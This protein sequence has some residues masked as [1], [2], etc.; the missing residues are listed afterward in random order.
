MVIEAVSRTP[1]AEMTYFLHIMPTRRKTPV[2]PNRKVVALAY[3]GLATFEFAI[4]VEVFG[5]H[6]PEVGP[7]W[8]EFAVA[9]VD[10][11]PLR[12]TGGI[13]VLVDGGLE[14]LADAGTIVLPG[15]R[16]VDSPIGARLKGALLS[17]HARGARIVSVCS[18]A[19]ALAQTGLLD[20]CHATT[21]WRYMERFRAQFPRVHLDTDVLY[22][23]AGRLFTSAGSAAG[24]DL[25][26]HLVRRDFGS[27]VTNVVAR[28]M[29][30]P[31]HRDG[32]QQ[33]YVEQP[34]PA[35]REGAVLS[36][37]LDSLRVRLNRS[38]SVQRL[39]REARMSERTFVRRFAAATGMPPGKWL[40][41]ERVRRAKHL[42]ETRALSIDATAAECGFADASSLW[43]HFKA[44]VGISP[45]AYRSRFAR[46]DTRAS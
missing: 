1:L 15:W 45:A 38:M 13:R 20:G 44:Q 25:C 8:Y 16:G 10:P 12:A 29:V 17:A 22:V 28:R 31:P 35:A 32:G 42:L 3:E 46:P 26:L 9:S 23:D 30:V 18:G 37:L 4:V 19:F 41:H 14:L 40:T 5:L 6:R 39:A 24:I 33:Q 2:L 34:V 43:R 36:P 27:R 21:H 11:P 7:D